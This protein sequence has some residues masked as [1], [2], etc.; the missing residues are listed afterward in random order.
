M[1]GQASEV[2]HDRRV[3]DLLGLNQLFAQFER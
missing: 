3:A 1:I 2:V